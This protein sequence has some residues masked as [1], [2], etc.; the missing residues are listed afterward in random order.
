MLQFPRVGRTFP[1]N[2]TDKFPEYDEHLAKKREPAAFEIYEDDS[3]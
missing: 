2:V 3:Q 1:I